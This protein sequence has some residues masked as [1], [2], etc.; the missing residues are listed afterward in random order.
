MRLLTSKLENLADG[1]ASRLASPGGVAGFYAVYGLIHAI[2]ASASGAALALDDVKLNV[3]TQ[4]LR[5]GYLPDNPP[6]FEWMLTGAQIFTGPSVVSFL[7]V[8]YALLLATGVL[9][10][11]IGRLLY[12]DARRAGLAAF[13]LVLLYQIGWN[14]HQAFTHSTAL[15]AAVML[16]WYALLRLGRRDDAIAYA[17]F[18]AA[19]ALGVLSKY[20]FAA[21]ALIGIVAALRSTRLR[22]ALAKPGI[23]LSLAVAV[24]ILVPHLHWV[25]TANADIA[26]T[27]GERL[28][29]GEASYLARISVALPN[30]LWAILSFGL[31]LV[32]L[33]ATPRTIAA[34]L[35]SAP[36][37][38]MRVMRDAAV[39][40]AVA[41]VLSVIALG[42]GNM[43]ERYAIAFLLPGLFWLVSLINVARFRFVLLAGLA[44]TL[45]IA[46]VR[47]V[48]R[49]VAG[50][51]FCSSCRQ[52]IPY[53]AL[54]ASIDLRR[55][56]ATTL[57][58][59]DEN[60]AGNLRRLYPSVRVL[61]SHLPTFNPSSEAR[62]APCLFVWSADLGEAPPL[63][64]TQSPVS[65][66]IE[67]VRAPWTRPFRKNDDR[68]TEWRIADIDTTTTLGASICRLE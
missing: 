34:A 47:V 56:A 55:S 54:K 31:P 67:T 29:G 11:M 19:I 24:L 66:D 16:F 60:T 1:F 8:K 61:S 28:L 37:E 27:A 12:D 49:G 26:T 50:P 62:G 33:V 42:L 20:S 18:G 39:L 38:F 57:V 22:R 23:V 64:W 10:F 65:N 36:D 58:A 30:A 2:V 44:I 14:Y 52:W 43:Q 4:S 63:E 45:F 9:T 68:V 48:E 32:L 21:S 59:H 41:L 25:L 46:G 15:I 40:G 7:I 3:L 5:A 53:D 51:P 13:S 35:R 6:L 17:L